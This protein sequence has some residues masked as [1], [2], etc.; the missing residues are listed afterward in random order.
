MSANCTIRG[1]GSS[2]SNRQWATMTIMAARSTECTRTPRAVASI[3]SPILA[4]A[5]TGRSGAR[6]WAAGMLSVP[7]MSGP[8]NWRQAGPTI[9]RRG[10][11]RRPISWWRQCSCPFTLRK[12]G[13]NRTRCTCWCTACGGM[14]HASTS[15]DTLIGLSVSP[16]S[17]A[18]SG[19]LWKTR[20]RSNSRMTGMTRWSPSSRSMSTLSSMMS[21]W[22]DMQS[23]DMQNSSEP[24]QHSHSL[25]VC[26]G[27]GL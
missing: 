18:L 10:H 5:R 2:S 26:P 24:E 11:P 25:P 19:P 21:S 6:Q 23:S 15:G 8:L 7:R 12:N 17:R 3:T 27:A 20:S 4:C 22:T 16:L 1:V 13:S 9:I 14:G